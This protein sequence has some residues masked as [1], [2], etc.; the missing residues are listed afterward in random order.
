MI[1]KEIRGINILSDPD[2]YESNEGSKAVSTNLQKKRYNIVKR[3]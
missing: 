1:S 2:F 3:P